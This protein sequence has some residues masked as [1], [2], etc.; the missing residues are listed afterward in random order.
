MMRIKAIVAFI[1]S[2]LF[3]LSGIVLAG[4]TFLYAFLDKGPKT[5]PFG[6]FIGFG[7]TIVAFFISFLLFRYYKRKFSNISTNTKNKELGGL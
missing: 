3:A 5:N 1:F 4:G 7:Y 6:G 2:V